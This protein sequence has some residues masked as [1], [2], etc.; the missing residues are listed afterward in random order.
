MRKNTVILL[1]CIAVA[2]LGLLAV[3]QNRQLRMIPEGSTAGDLAVERGTRSREP[4]LGEAVQSTSSREEHRA[5]GGQREYVDEIHQLKSEL[6]TVET[7]LEALRD[8][9][10]DHTDE[11]GESQ[12]KSPMAGLAE[13]IRDPAMKDML[14]GQ[15]KMALTMNYGA[16]FEDMELP[17]DELDVFKE[18][19]V[20]RQMAFM[21]MSSGMVKAPTSGAEIKERA[22]SVAAVTED[23]NERI[24]SA[25]GEQYYEMY[26]EYEETLADRAQV[27]LF[28]QQLATSN[29]LTEAQ[30]YDLIAALHDERTAFYASAAADQEQ[31]SNPT[32]F[33]EEDLSKKLEWLAELHEN[34][35]DRARGIL[36]ESQLE[37]FT[38]SV[39]QMRAM[40]EMGIRMSVKIS[41]EP[42][43]EEH[44]E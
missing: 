16:L 23:F 28:K 17:P 8:R 34:Y 29:Q 41:A 10:I 2:A 42:E 7:E 37:Q 33:T 21:E 25:V 15:Q 13:M 31:P 43:K 32:R 30:E 26:R 44:V 20:D 36:S 3:K 19:L 4:A 6:A 12:S 35:I 24:R 11:Q 40:Q 22:E 39:E 27:N 14:R 1:L 9:P 38:E 5:V 18:L